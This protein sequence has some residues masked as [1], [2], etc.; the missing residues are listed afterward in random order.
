MAVSVGA[1]SA[2]LLADTKRFQNEMK[3]AREELSR[4][5]KMGQTVN[6]VLGGI[7]KV[8]A[9]AGAG[10]AAITGTVA[11][12]VNETAKY[13]DEIDK[14]S[15][16]TGV[17]REE[18]QELRYAFSQVGADVSVLERATVNL[19]RRLRDSS[20]QATA[21]ARRFEDLGAQIFRDDGTFRSQA[22]LFTDIVDVL[23]QM[24][25]ET[26]RNAL[27]SAVFGRGV[28][29]NMIPV[30]D[31][32]GQGMAELREEARALGGVMREDAV[33]A[34][35]AFGDQILRLQTA[36]VGMR[37]SMAAEFMPVAT[38]FADWAT[39]A[40]VAFGNLSQSQRD[41]I[42]R[43]ISLAAIVLAVV[44]AFGALA[45]GIKAVAFAFSPVM[46]L[47]RGVGTAFSF[48]FGWVGILRT[49][50]VAFAGWISS[51]WVGVLARG[52]LRPL[53]A[54]LG[55]VGWTIAAVGLLWAAWKN[56]WF[57]IRDILTDVWQSYL[58]PVLDALVA[59]LDG[60]VPQAM[61]SLR[62][63]W[64][65]VW[66]ALSGTLQAA[67]DTIG[68]IIQT[69]AGWIGDTLTAAIAKTEPIW[70]AFWAVLEAVVGAAWKA[71]QPLFD[72]ISDW[73]GLSLADKIES[74]QGVWS[75]AWGAISD[76]ASVAA[77][78]IR[79]A[80]EAVAG[81]VGDRLAV[82]I[83]ATEPIW[84]AAWGLITLAVQSARDA[85]AP[86]FQA[87]SDWLHS[88]L[89][90]RI[91]SVQ[92]V[93]S[94]AWT[95]IQTAAQ[96]VWDVLSALGAAALAGMQRNLEL[97]AVV[98]DTTWSGIG[99]VIDAFDKAIRGVLG[100][101]R[102]AVTVTIPDAM[103]AFKTT[104]DSV[105][106]SAGD[107]IQAFWDPIKRIFDA[108]TDFFSRTFSLDFNLPSVSGV[109]SSIGSSIR[110]GWDTFTG[111]LGF[112]RGAILPGFGGGD[113]IPA[114]LE[115]GEA[116]VPARIVRD[117]L[118]AIIGWFRA[119]GVR[120]Q[121][122]L[123]TGGPSGERDIIADYAQRL[124]SV[125]PETIADE[126]Q[127]FFEATKILP[128]P[129]TEAAAT[130]S[131][132]EGPTPDEVRSW[133]QQVTDFVKNEASTVWQL[134]KD[135]ATPAA[136]QLQ[137]F[138]AS[139]AGAFH[140]M[141]LLATVLGHLS[142]PVQALLVPLAMVAEIIAGALMPVFEAL[143]PVIQTFGQLLLTGVQVIGGV[144]NALIDIVSMIPFVNLRN[145]KLDLDAVSEG[146]RQ[147]TELTWEEAKAKASLTEETQKTIGAMRGVPSIFRAV[148]RRW[149]AVAPGSAPTIGVAQV[150][151]G[152]NPQP[153]AR[154]SGVNVNV[155]V[156]GDTYGVDDLDERIRY[157]TAQGARAAS[158]A[159]HGTVGAMG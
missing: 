154:G 89:E 108:I 75:A 29:L 94:A 17:A 48:V 87:I 119:H 122:G 55:P 40:A 120:A 33:L 83:E 58:K 9:A 152:A 46:G 72:S 35:V 150:F 41:N 148:A 27:A 11:L 90:R 2:Q 137:A 127:K 52:L 136:D 93:W 124:V 101:L 31:A 37:R 13:A 117:G 54:L 15:I 66:G 100:W 34:S 69:I 76:A 106:K 118:G 158:M 67:S 3:G 79:T 26:E 32:G 132:E 133:W 116:V 147:L 50:F 157:A 114:L 39:Q 21:T 88:S 99:V 92:S 4:F 143:F 14:M 25:N 110:S 151:G 6:S 57:G 80:I 70:S 105:W 140:P 111:W 115:A 138:A 5:Q 62:Q 45:V 91:E 126:I 112:Q 51:T 109:T 95:G 71:L 146:Q 81:Y 28:A 153:V 130:A 64:N 86:V 97:F 107:G 56:N 47:L 42:V 149:D 65:A 125:L 73:L 135:N 141:N 8:G 144:W 20:G 36:V 19:T 74:V 96:A 77:S 128:T 38:L 68:P 131:R 44:A 84:S 12:A 156:E 23:S 134:V 121:T 123:I 155:Y 103:L 16:R 98:W 49:A 139:V 82:V 1:I 60:A 145:Y 142:S 113:R 63:V 78:A 102:D 129:P 53:L 18:L 43:W 104:W 61:E 85:L 159:Q 59:W 22:D 10:F 30:L 7:A 24:R